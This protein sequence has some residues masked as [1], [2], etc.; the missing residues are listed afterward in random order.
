LKI[1][2]FVNIEFLKLLLE[3]VETAL[4]QIIG[5]FIDDEVK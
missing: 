4:K 1:I 2:D 3:G 5:Q